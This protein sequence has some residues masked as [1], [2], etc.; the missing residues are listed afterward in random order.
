MPV[1]CIRTHFSICLLLSTGWIVSFDCLWPLATKNLSCSIENSWKFYALL[2]SEDRWI[3]SELYVWGVIASQHTFPS[4]FISVISSRFNSLII[5]FLIICCLVVAVVT[6]QWST[7]TTTIT[8]SICISLR[9]PSITCWVQKLSYKYTTIARNAV[10]CL[11]PQLSVFC[12]L[13]RV[14]RTNNSSRAEEKGRLPHRHQTSHPKLNRHSRTKWYGN[15]KKIRR[16]TEERNCGYWVWGD[17][18][19]SYKVH[20]CKQYVGWDKSFS[21]C[22]EPMRVTITS[23]LLCSRSFMYAHDITMLRAHSVGCR[24]RSKKLKMPSLLPFRPKFRKLFLI[25]I[26]TNWF[27]SIA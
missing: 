12:R 16:S 6:H 19:A 23:L 18:G 3:T 21:D 14:H 17:I 22:L 10:Y 24:Q 26:F 1:K 27:C 25:F 7:S 20:M 2:G 13:F 15:Q 4:Y 11:D 5:I 8:V 9:F